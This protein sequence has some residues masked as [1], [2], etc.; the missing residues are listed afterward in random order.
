MT[1]WGKDYQGISLGVIGTDF[2]FGCFLLPKYWGV[3]W[4]K[5][6]MTHV[7]SFPSWLAGDPWVRTVSTLYLRS[8]LPMWAC[9]VCW[10][11][12]WM[13]ALWMD[14]RIKMIIGDHQIFVISEEIRM[15]L[16]SFL[17]RTLLCSPGWTQT[18]YPLHSA[19]RASSW[20]VCFPFRIVPSMVA[21]LA[22]SPSHH[23]HPRPPGCTLLPATTL[24]SYKIE[25][26]RTTP[27]QR[28]HR[29]PQVG[30]ELP[31]SEIACR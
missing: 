31:S 28:A 5:D 17:D 22:D 18:I 29:E 30:L 21:S 24:L 19:G 13:R 15:I 16:L 25:R 7:S 2:S 1:S 23:S 20:A 9:I 6:K 27:S 11:V 14:I 4:A 12:V 26:M 10:P 8:L 3:V